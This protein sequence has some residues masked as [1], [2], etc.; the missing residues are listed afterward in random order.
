MTI[1][2]GKKETGN[3][4]HL[5]CLTQM[6]DVR[7]RIFG[8]I[9]QVFENKSTDPRSGC[10]PFSII[11]LILDEQIQQIV[12]LFYFCFIIIMGIKTEINPC[13]IFQQVCR[14]TDKT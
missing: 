3:Y 11:A 5:K 9:F 12:Y 13:F 1:C 4:V 10:V 14:H 2:R 6:F 8:H 7:N